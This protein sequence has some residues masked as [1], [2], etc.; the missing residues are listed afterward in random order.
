MDHLRGY[1]EAD[2]EYLV[3]PK[4]LAVRLHKPQAV[5]F[6]FLRVPRLISYIA[7]GFCLVEQ[8]HER[9]GFFEFQ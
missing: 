5:G 4:R 3:N 2:L 7:D 9:S 6:C 1:C 8:V